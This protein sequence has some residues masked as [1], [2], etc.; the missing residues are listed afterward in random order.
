MINTVVLIGRLTKDPILRYT[1]NGIAVASF[2][3][4]VNRIK[5]G[6]NGQQE[7]DFVNCVAWRKQAENLCNFMIKG[8]AVGIDGRIQTRSYDGQDGNRV[9]VTEVVAEQVQFLTSKKKDGNQSQGNYSGNQSTSQPQ[10]NNQ[11]TNE[12]PFAGDG[13]PIDI[14]DDDLPF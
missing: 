13:K 14:N 12:D 5:S 4:A 10:G 11:N 7:A 8:D 6:S 1:Q 2:T 9:F 3:I